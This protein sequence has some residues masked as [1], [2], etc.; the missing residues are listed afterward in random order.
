M[1]LLTLP[2]NPQDLNPVDICHG[3]N[4]LVHEATR[5]AV[6]VS[7]RHTAVHI[8][9]GAD[10]DTESSEFI[11]LGLRVY[12]HSNFISAACSPPKLSQRTLHLG[13]G[14]PSDPMPDWASVNYFV[15]FCYVNFWPASMTLSKPFQLPSLQRYH[16][17]DNTV[18]TLFYGSARKIIQP[19][20][21]PV[22][23]EYKFICQR[24]NNHLQYSCA[25]TRLLSSLNT[26]SLSS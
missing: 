20:S 26:G 22:T 12:Q 6:P 10:G 24:K 19:H 15:L 11:M 7:G 13:S 17:G 9:S 3:R 8:K 23:R 1:K 18:F 5:N 2:I 16:W 25:C 4:S 14:L 21:F